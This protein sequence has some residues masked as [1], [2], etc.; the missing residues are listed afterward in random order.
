MLYGDWGT[1]KAY[2]LGLAFAIAGHASMF[3]LVAMSVLTVLVGLCYIIICKAYPD[4]G[5][6]YS[7]VRHRSH[8]LAVVGALLLVADYVVTAAISSIEAFH[9]LGVSNP[10]VWAIGILIFLGVI[11]IVGP[12]K[13]GNGAAIIAIL[14]TAV[15]AVLCVAVMPHV[16]RVHIDP[17]QGTFFDNWTKFVG[18]VLALSGIEAIANVTGIMKEPVKRTAK[19]A[20]VPVMIEVVVVSLILGAAMNAIPG[21][22][23]RTEDMIRAIGE[24]YIG[25]W[26][27]HLVAFLLGFL[28]ISACNTAI[29]GLVSIF[30]LMSKD[31]E[32]P[33]IFSNLN[34]YGMPWFGLLVSVAAPIAVLLFDHD[35]RHL[36]ALYAIGVVGAITINVIACCTNKSLPI[37]KTERVML[38]VVGIVMLLVEATIIYEKHN[39]VIFALSVLGIGLSLRA[40]SKQLEKRV[41]P[42]LEVLGI[43]VLTVEEAKDL[44]PL[45]KGSTLVAIKSVSTALVEEAVLHAKGKGEKV[46][47]T[48]LVEE[49]PPG[50]AYPV[51]VEPA[52]DSVAALN[53][54]VQEF[55]K[56][57]ITSVPLWMMGDNAGGLIVKTAKDLNLDTVMIGATKRTTVERMLRGEVLKTITEQLPADKHLLI[58]N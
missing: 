52:A 38:G 37:K 55:E 22:E 27:G 4:G 17:P 9:Y 6:V 19:R 32:I 33:A 35:V 20:I 44:M 49:K 23:G 39:A 3:F 47:Y 16:G 46:V 11:N 50:W 40:I 25:P 1:S 2:V 8:T 57:G 15:L 5:G 36:A 28:L 56:R 41:A 53:Q 10:L 45:Y 12:T 43:N 26:F 31:K 14:T 13:S 7:A 58:C 18:I 30:F 42:A 54:A 51:E 29:S 34:R 21:L 24:Y 48:L